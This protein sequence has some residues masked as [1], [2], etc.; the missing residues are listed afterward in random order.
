MTPI[1]MLQDLGQS[2]WYDDVGRELLISGGFDD[3]ISI[4]ITGVTANPAILER[5]M[6]QSRVYD[7]A[8]REKAH[9]VGSVQELYDV[10]VF[11]DLRR[12]ADLLRPV[13][14]RSQG[15]DGFVSLEVAP[16]LADDTEGTVAEE[17]RMFESLDRPNV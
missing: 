17:R 13:Y 15:R 6:T 1:Q 3:L 9:R 2:V 11:E 12:A 5:A 4:G 14:V 10:L 8:I 7:D 16:D